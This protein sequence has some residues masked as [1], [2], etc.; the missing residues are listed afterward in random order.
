[1]EAIIMLSNMLNILPITKSRFIF[2]PK[3]VLKRFW[4]GSTQ[5]QFAVYKTR[6][7]YLCA[8]HHDF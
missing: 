7:S 6:D 4:K 1:M 8:K 2:A 5:D 3:I